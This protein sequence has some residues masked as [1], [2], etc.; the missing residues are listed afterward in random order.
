MFSCKKCNI[1][2]H[3]DP[4]C[5]SG[6]NTCDDNSDS[7]FGSVNDQHKSDFFDTEPSGDE[8]AVILLHMHREGQMSITIRRPYTPEWH[9]GSTLNC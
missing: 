4:D 9:F 8:C 3:F 1:F 7:E 5:V 2:V 6:Y